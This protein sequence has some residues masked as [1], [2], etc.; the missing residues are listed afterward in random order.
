MSLVRR[1][2][3]D[4]GFTAIELMLVLSILVVAA[5]ALLPGIPAFTRSQRL[6]SS[7]VR[8]AGMA[9]YAGDWSVLHE[10]AVALRFD[11]EAGAFTLA[12]VEEDPEETPLAV[13]L[14]EG[15]SVE[16]EAEGPPSL[17]AAW[18]L[19]RLSADMELAAVEKAAGEEMAPGDQ[20]LFY[21][22]GRS[23]D[24][25]LVLALGDQRCTVRISGRR[26]RVMTE[27]GDALEEDAGPV[28]AR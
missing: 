28:G 14:P 11:D 4:S 9:R 16:V 3:P 24:A 8:L 22:D 23:D 10:R 19:L 12:V 15:E 25:T 26:G 1:M 7:A 21:P 27:M 20:V 6:R 13:P 5:I 2:S 17:E 18:R